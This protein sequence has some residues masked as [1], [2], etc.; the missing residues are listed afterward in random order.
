MSFNK[1]LS[2]KYKLNRSF[3]ALDLSTSNNTDQLTFNLGNKKVIVN[4]N[5]PST[6]RTYTIPDV[7][8]DGTFYISGGNQPVT[9]SLIPSANNT[10]DIG[11]STYNWSNLYINIIINTGNNIQLGTGSDYTNLTAQNLSGGGI[12]TVTIP[13]YTDTVCLI[14]SP[15]TLTNKTITS[16]TIN[17]ANIGTSTLN[18]PVFLTPAFNG[19]CTGVIQTSGQY[20]FKAYNNVGQTGVTGAGEQYTIIFDTVDFQVGTGYDSSTGV[21]T[22]PINGLY[23]FVAN[24]QTGGWTTSNTDA[25]CWFYHNTTKYNMHMTSNISFPTGYLVQNFST[26][27][28]MK[29]GDYITVGIEVDGSSTANIN[30]IS[31]SMNT[32][33]ICN[34]LMATP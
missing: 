27:F 31:G 1:T 18:T 2:N 8:A 21:F 20:C 24:I 29:S 34:L 15:Q 22:A 19:I 25:V 6:T 5:T 28:N 3:E 11:S 17:G 7:G 16:P 4:V 12:N 32:N 33:L 9:S 23:H 10:Y 26:T 14:A 30:I 13:S